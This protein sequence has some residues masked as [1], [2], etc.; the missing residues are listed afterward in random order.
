MI[1]RRLIKKISNNLLVK[2]GVRLQALDFMIAKA[3]LPPFANQ[4]RNVVIESPRRL[5]NTHKIFLGDDIWI[6]PNSLILAITE[7]PTMPMKGPKN[8]KIIQTFDPIIRIG[9]RV[10]ATGGL[11]IAAHKEISI[12]DDVL[13]ASNINHQ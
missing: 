5:G 6:G 13:F 2:L 11:Q 1:L 7:Y 10:T 12:E 3:S 4:P 8:R 9:N